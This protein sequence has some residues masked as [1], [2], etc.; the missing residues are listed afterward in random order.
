MTTLQ[1]YISAASEPGATA[2][3]KAIAAAW[4]AGQSAGQEVAESIIREKLS[5]LPAT[6]Y[7]G[8]QR[9]TVNHLLADNPC[10][11]NAPI[12]PAFREIL[13]WEIQL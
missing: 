10:A 6:R 13:A 11:R 3:S 9:S 8:V 7:S 12:L 1:D 2:I 5:N 4:W